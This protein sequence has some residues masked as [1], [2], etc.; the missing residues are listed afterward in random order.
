VDGAPPYWWRTPRGG[1]TQGMGRAGWVGRS[2]KI[3]L[4]IFF[5]SGNL[6]AIVG[7]ECYLK[8]EIFLKNLQILF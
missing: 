2:W 1:R 3:F 4:G 8:G 6:E 7:V 5:L